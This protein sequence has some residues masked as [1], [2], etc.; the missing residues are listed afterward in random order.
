MKSFAFRKSAFGAVFAAA[1]ALTG[2]GGGDDV[3]P[4]TGA[5][6]GG[7]NGTAT[8]GTFNHYVT[9]EIK[10]GGSVTEATS[11]GLDLDGKSPANDNVVGKAL[12]QFGG[13][14]MITF[15]TEIADALNA[16]SFIIL[17][18][19]R[20]DAL[21]ADTTVSWQVYLGDP[22]PSCEGDPSCFNGN[23]SF[24]L[25]AGGP[26]TA[27]LNGAISGGNYTAQPGN[28]SLELSLVSGSDPLRV[29]LIGAKIESS[30]TATTCSGRLGGAIKQTD[31]D[32]T[33]FPFIAAQ[34]QLRVA[35]E[36]SCLTVPPGS[37][38]P[39][40]I[41]T[42]LTVLDTSPKNGM[43]SS[44]EVKGVVGAILAPDLDLLKADGTAG[45]DGVAESVSLGLGFKCAKAT[46]TA[47]GEQ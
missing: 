39:S 37:A 42:L 36:P 27:K 30:I 28:L 45:T 2:C 29:N 7:N 19:V 41:K 4:G 12:Q 3:D 47:P 32:T 34:I 21:T 11:F 5:D 38:C 14:A 16:G 33:I 44:A 6:A 24:T 25:K 1:V 40:S 8:T 13:L 43:V 22:K 20:A 10:V 46:F 15:D 31:L 23:G 9:S 18:S 26:T 17:H 35:A